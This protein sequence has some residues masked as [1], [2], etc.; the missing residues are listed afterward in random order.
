[1]N[2]LLA[3]HD[4]YMAHWKASGRR[5]LMYAAPCCGATIETTAPPKG[6]TWDSLTICPHCGEMHFKVVT[7]NRVTAAQ[8]V[9]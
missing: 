7:F 6:E 3:E 5:T 8:G 2:K 1:M 4:A 9:Q